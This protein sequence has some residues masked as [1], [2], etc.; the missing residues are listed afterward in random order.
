MTH[1]KGLQGWKRAAACVQVQ[2]EVAAANAACLQH[3]F[4]AAV[5]QRREAKLLDTAREFGK[6]YAFEIERLSKLYIHDMQARAHSLPFVVKGLTAL[7]SACAA[8]LFGLACTAA[9][10]WKCHDAALQ[11]PLVPNLACCCMPPR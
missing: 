1:C 9:C 7:P 2:E 11:G 6:L 3:K 5:A 10:L 4:A 8:F